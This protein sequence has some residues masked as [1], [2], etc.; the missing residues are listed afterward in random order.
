MYSVP[1]QPCILVKLFKFRGKERVM[2]PHGDNMGQAQERPA[3]E[4]PK[5]PH[6]KNFTDP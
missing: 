1:Q 6:P 5:P 4:N 3:R 2:R